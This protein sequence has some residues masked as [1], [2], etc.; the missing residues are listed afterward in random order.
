MHTKQLTLSSLLYC[1]MAEADNS[2]KL[3]IIGD[4]NVGKTCLLEVFEKGE[5]VEGPYRP[6]IFHNS[7]KEIEHPTNPEEKVK[8]QLWVKLNL[9]FLSLRYSQVGHGRTRGLQGSAHN[10]LQRHRRPPHWVQH[11]RAG[12]SCQ[13]GR[14]LAGRV[15]AWEP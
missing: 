10:V 11:R 3:V 14:S 7:E 12:L 13:C 4:G 15:Q 1:V 6:T 5:F 2:R 9:V 8:F